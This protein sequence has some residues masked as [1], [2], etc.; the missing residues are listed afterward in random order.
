MLR[1]MS[2]FFFIDDLVTEKTS[3]NMLPNILKLF[4]QRNDHL[5]QET[6]SHNGRVPS[7]LVLAIKNKQGNNA[8]IYIF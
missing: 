6:D 1:R 3:F 7:K 5:E 4:S 2:F 8:C